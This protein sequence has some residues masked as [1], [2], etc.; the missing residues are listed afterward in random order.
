MSLW[1]VLLRLWGSGHGRKVAVFQYNDE[2][3][4]DVRNGRRACLCEIYEVVK[5]FVNC[6]DKFEAKWFNIGC[7]EA[8]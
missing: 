6:L 2:G 5:F 4:G 1:V 3:G 8:N 7:Y